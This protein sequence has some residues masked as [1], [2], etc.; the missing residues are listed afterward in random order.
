MRA[1]V[2][3]HGHGCHP[4]ARFLKPGFKHCFVVAEAGDYHVRLD[5]MDGKPVLDVVCGSDYDLA[6]FYRREGYTV[7]K[8]SQRRTPPL[9]PFVPSNCVGLVKAFLCI[10]APFA[11]TPYALYRHLTHHGLLPGKSIISPSKPKV[12]KAPPPP[13]PPPER[14]DPAILEAAQR[15]RREELQRRGRR[16]TILTGGGG[17]GPSAPLGRPMAS[18]GDQ[19]GA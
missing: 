18:A 15:Q 11:V 1:L 9:W 13:P 10:S 14:D 6:T 5:G 16:S 4:L 19:L 7:V 17:P 2:V 12:P 3:F 8:T